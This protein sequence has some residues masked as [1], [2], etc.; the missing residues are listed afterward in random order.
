MKMDTGSTFIEHTKYKYLHI[1]AQQMG[2]PQPLLE[3]EAIPDVETLLLPVPHNIEMKPLDLQVAINNRKSIRSYNQEQLSKEELSMLLWCTQG[4]KTLVPGHA[5]FRTVPSAGARHAFE[6]YLLINRVTD[7]P[8]GLYHFRASE[9]AIQRITSE[10]NLAGRIANGALGQEMIIQAAV[11]FI[12][13]AVIER[14]KWR[15]GERGYRY[16]FLDAGHVCQNLYLSSQLMDAGVCA[17]AA[18]DDDQMNKILGIDG[19]DEFVVYM[20]SV[21]KILE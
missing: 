18:F 17:I 6:T 8:H 4:V 16:L 21:G 2:S 12:W 11:C 7:V 1:S 3:K 20:A 5:T 15:Y 10:E 9:H 13:V 19:K 14:M